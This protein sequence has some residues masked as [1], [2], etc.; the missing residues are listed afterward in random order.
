VP[1]DFSP[2]SL[3]AVSYALS[4]LKDFGA[5]LQLVHVFEADYPLS[6]FTAMPLTVSEEEVRRRI[7]RHLRNVTKTCPAKVRPENL[8]VVKGRPFEEICKLARDENIDL[9]VI[10]T[11]GNT[12][13]KHLTLGST[14]E[15]VV[16][17]SPC[18][19]LVIREHG[20]KRK[21]T[22]A[23]SAQTFKRILVPVDFSECSLKGLA[24]G[25]ALAKKFGAKLILLHSVHVQYFV[26]NDEYAR[27]DFPEVMRQA[28]AIGREQL[29]DLVAKTNWE[30]I[31]VE[32]SLQIV[33]VGDEICSRA[34][35]FGADLIVT[36]T[37]GRTGLKRALLGSTAEYVVRHAPC[38]VLAVPN[39]ER[40]ALPPAGRK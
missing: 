11:R 17:Y 34:A 21:A 31:E 9:I 3:G 7:R 18:P 22:A 30:G 1:I 6:T 24:Y 15:R 28:E 33:H 26:T 25:K 16:R 5:D 4:L 40:P 39:Y 20:S 29:H 35:D 37:H 23:Q 2:D 32:P 10:A 38:P 14:A 12:G 19:V 36:S 13:L 27:Y 8:H